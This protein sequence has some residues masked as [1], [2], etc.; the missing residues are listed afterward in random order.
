MVFPRHWLLDICASNLSSLV[1]LIQ[2]HHDVLLQQMIV[3]NA[4]PCTHCRKYIGVITF[5]VIR[6]GNCHLNQLHLVFQ[7]IDKLNV[8]DVILDKVVPVVRIEILE[9]IVFGFEFLFV[10]FYRRNMV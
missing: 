8:Y 3:E 5:C 2:R 9:G 4:V 6:H 1:I 10:E 7:F